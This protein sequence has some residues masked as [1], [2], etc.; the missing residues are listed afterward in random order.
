MGDISDVIDIDSIADE[1]EYLY[2][3]KQAIADAINEVG[4]SQGITVTSADT[5]RSY[6]D[7]IKKFGQCEVGKISVRTTPEY[8]ED[9]GKCQTFEAPEGKVWKEVKVHIDA[10]SAVTDDVDPLVISENGYFDVNEVSAA[11]FDYSQVQNPTGN[12]K[13]KGYYIKIN[14][15]Y[16]PTEDTEVD[17]N[18]TYYTKDGTK[19]YE[20]ASSFIINVQRAGAAPFTC[21]FCDEAGN[22]IEHHEGIPYGGWCT[23]EGVTPVSPAG[24]MFQGWNPAPNNIQT[25][26]KCYPKFF[27]SQVSVDEIGMSWAEIVTSHGRDIPI[28]AFKTLPLKDNKIV[29][30]NPSIKGEET[31][32][33]MPP[34]MQ[35]VFNGEDVSETSWLSMNI[36]INYEASSSID[37]RNETGNPDDINQN[38]YC[39]FGDD[40]GYTLYD[41]LFN[42][43]MEIIPDY[44]RQFIIPVTK[45]FSATQVVDGSPITDTHIAA[46][47][48]NLWIP[49][50]REV[51]AYMII[52]T[53]FTDSWS[54]ASQRGPYYSQAF[55]DQASRVINPD[56]P[57]AGNK[58]RYDTRD[59]YYGGYSYHRNRVYNCAIM[60]DGS[61]GGDYPRQSGLR[62]G[63]CL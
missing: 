6:A 17:P 19:E 60:D 20:T 22:I 32:N 28:G 15:K 33:V 30:Y 13:Q 45:Y 36:V 44:I 10:W 24:L 23:Y 61:V 31:Y 62:I 3:T 9:I 18:K 46:K 63:F 8:D 11:K 41:A 43:F 34:I 5:F 50:L 37:D 51:G 2:G 49:S 1:L 35:K 16:Y 54:C 42:A 48:C 52:N 57:N 53:P 55:P 7:K 59:C 29:I 4:E 38:G 12:P 25:N 21:D 47:Q 27:N 14:G 40:S 58:V 26:M 39:T 56:L